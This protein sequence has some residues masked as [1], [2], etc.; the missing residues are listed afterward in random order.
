MTR[1]SRGAIL[2]YLVGV[3][4]IGLLI[5]GLSG[6]TLARKSP[7]RLP[8]AREAETAWMAKYQTELG[9]TD[10]QRRTVQPLLTDAVKKMSGIWYRAIM[11][12]G[13]VQQGV[14][15]RIEPLLN[16]RQRARLLE[17]IQEARRQRLLL[18]GERFD[19]QT[20]KQDHIWYAAAV[21]DEAAIRR[22]LDAG[23]DVNQ[24]DLAFGMT[25]LAVA[26][27]HGR[28]N[29][30]QL[31]LARGAQVNARLPDGNTALHA[32]AFF[33]R[34]EVVK[35][36][37]AAGADPTLRNEEGETPWQALQADW[38]TVQFIADVL[39]VELDRDKVEAGRRVVAGILEPA[40]SAPPAQRGPVIPDNPPGSSLT[41]EEN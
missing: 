25:P 33:G 16:Q 14:E 12:M 29:A 30:V 7:P 41:P 23:V 32:A 3:F 1:E 4:L 39:Q 9:L 22:H 20:G 6:Y 26:A 28:T 24:E 15:R 10:E 38:E 21:G 40:T 37:L 36:L 19:E 2:G 18:A 8:S 31:L 11:T 13:A 35:T 34:V 27:V 5:G 17:L